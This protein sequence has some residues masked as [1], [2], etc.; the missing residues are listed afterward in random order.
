MHSGAIALGH[1]SDD[2]TI[3]ELSTTIAQRGGGKSS[4]TMSFHLA[5]SVVRCSCVVMLVVSEDVDCSGTFRLR[6]SLGIIRCP[7]APFGRTVLVGLDGVTQTD[8]V[9]SIFR[10]AASFGVAG[11]ALS[12]RASDPFLRKALR[13]SMGRAFAVP[14]GRA[15]FGEWPGSLLKLKATGYT[16]VA[17]EDTPDAVPLF[18][19]SAPP[20]CV[21]IFG[22]EQDGVSSTILSIAD[23]VVKVG[24]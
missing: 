16:I 1:R 2:P 18:L 10:N 14:W 17:A 15:A 23:V 12:D 7:G 11:V 19:F 21:V 9:G 20:K 13:V 4:G 5:T 24:L 22:N 8:N 6:R 3:E